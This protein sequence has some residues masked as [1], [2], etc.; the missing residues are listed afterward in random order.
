[1]R[2]IFERFL[3]NKRYGEAFEALQIMWNDEKD[4]ESVLRFRRIMT[5]AVKTDGSRELA[6]LVK[7]SWFISAREKFR[8]YLVCVEWD[9]PS[10]DKFFLPRACYLDRLGIIKGYQMLADGELDLL[11]VSLPKRAGKALALDTPVCTPHGFV[12]M[13]EIKVG[14]Y[15]TG[16]D[17]KPC[18]VTGVYPQGKVPVYEVRFSDGAVVKTCGEHLW[19]V[20]WHDTN[21]RGREQQYFT[22]I[23]STKEI[24]ETPI[25]AKTH[26]LYSVRF[27]DAVEFEKKELPL[28]PYIVGALIGD[29]CLRD[30]T[31]VITSFDSETVERIAELL[32]DTDEIYCQDAKKGRYLI[33]HKGGVTNGGHKRSA[34]YDA[35]LGLGLAG[36]LSYD[37][38]I[39]KG[40]I[41]T[42]KADRYEL[43]CGLLD[44]DGCCDQKHIEFST[45]SFELARGVQFLVRSLGGKSNI[46]S[47]MGKYRGKDGK[48]IETTTNYRV[49]IQ[50]PKGTKPF[51]ITR[52]RE[53]YAPKRENLYHY[54][55]SITPIGE[56]YA[57]CI[58]VDNPD[59]LYLATEW[60]IPTHNSQTE[61]NFVN[62][63]SGRRPNGSSLIEGSGDALVESFY[64]GCTEY[65]NKDSDYSYYEIFPKCKVVQTNAKM[66][67]LNLNE[68]SRFPTLMCRSID[69][70]QVGLSEAT[71]VMVLDDCIE[72]REEALNRARL[73]AKWDVVNGDVLGRAL[74]GTP[75]V[76]S[77][78]RYSLYDII[79][80][81]KEKGEASGWRMM[82]IEYPAL[83]LETDE[84]NYEY[85]NPKLERKIFTTDFFRQ[86]RATLT[87]EQWE[88][89]FQ[90]QPFE[91]KGLLFPEDDLNRY[92]ELPV[93]VDPD[94]VM[95]VC[96]TAEGKGDSVAFPIGYVYGE[97]VYIED[98]VF[99]D[100][101][102]EHTKAEVAS[103][104]IE[105]KVGSA[106]FE[107]NS[108]GTYYARDVDE[109]VKKLG[110]KCSIKTKRTISNKETRIELASANILHHFYFKD[111]SKYAPNSQ[112]GNF[113]REVTGYTRLGKVKH[114]DAPDSL[115]LFEN[116]MRVILVPTLEVKKRY[117]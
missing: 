108:A 43:L 81:L 22:K 50:F 105:H 42:S 57:Q 77:G 28:H 18:K 90:Q 14:D 94:Y 115:S 33:R 110:G 71:N 55:E 11:T 102:P 10:T 84:S 96:D 45:V 36:K 89:E 72:G 8:D 41:Y 60:F 79:G 74:E 7:K 82:S 116:E 4:Y 3:G 24:M 85:Y 64:K 19:E 88:S 38:F 61:I 117:F 23:M 65:L 59:H 47:R 83:D 39:P 111:K 37:K 112:Y 63:L 58:C 114:D 15:V 78:T 54:I 29:G 103:K 113:M 5:E 32:P 2:D 6:N 107:S 20:K 98:V 75:I 87:K 66:H 12:P 69:A 49:T 44:T 99:D 62:F 68:E 51:Y 93:D 26:N 48:A 101:T 16:R 86:Q 52:K 104:I 80:R 106:T 40:Y 53:R 100:A 27:C 91:A 67:T 13:G 34:T 97:D 30:K 70:T 95:A 31:P 92:M 9:R 56:D 35:L 76:A 21:K 17:G 25:K 46:R 109:M 1:M 73:D